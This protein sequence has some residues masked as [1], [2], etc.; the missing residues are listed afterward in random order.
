MAALVWF[1][2]LLF[3][4]VLILLDLGVF[5]RKA[6]EIKVPEALAW[7]AVWVVLALAFNI[8]IY[9]LYENSWLGWADIPVHHLY[10][11]QAALQFFTGD[12][13][14][15]SLSIDNL[16]IIAMI[17]AA[18]RVPL[19]EQH[20][21][22]FWGIFA[23]LVLRGLMIAGGVALITRFEWLSYL[24]G[25]LLVS[26]SKMLIARHDNIDPDRNLAVRLARKLYPFSSSRRTKLCSQRRKLLAINPSLCYTFVA[27]K[28]NPSPFAWTLYEQTYPCHR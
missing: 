6:H 11:L 15:K 4:F 28:E 21:V 10:G 5:H 8:F 9:Y 19:T 12:L 23:A 14:E 7:T 22:L 27:S 16:F 24:F 26:A 13:V 1:R 3:V 20:R 17:F 18:F 2:F 25:L